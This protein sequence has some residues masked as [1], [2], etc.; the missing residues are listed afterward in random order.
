MLPR[1]MLTV[2]EARKR[3]NAIKQYSSL[4]RGLQRSRCAIWRSAARKYPR[5]GA[6]RPHHNIGFDLYCSL[7][8]RRF[9][10]QGRKT[11]PRLEVILRTDFVATRE[12]GVHE[13]WQQLAPRFFPRATSRGPTSHP[14]LSSPRGDRHKEQLD[15]LAKP[16]VTATESSRSGENLMTMSAIK[17][18]AAARKI[19]VVEVKGR[20]GDAHARR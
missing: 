17:I 2:G 8:G 4:G 13:G 11:R 5:H 20:Q 3:I 14:G 16:G 10:A 1:E 12:S 18:A 15:Q 7:L 19:T 9:E 6:E